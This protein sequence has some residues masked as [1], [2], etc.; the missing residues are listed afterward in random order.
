MGAASGCNLDIIIKYNINYEKIGIRL[1][2]QAVKHKHYHI[3]NYIVNLTTISSIMKN[4]LH[5][6]FILNKI[7]L[8]QYEDAVSYIQQNMLIHNCDLT[9]LKYAIMADQFDFFY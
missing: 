5:E 6:I 9:I 4:R 1:F 8:G 2:V 7:K 3:F